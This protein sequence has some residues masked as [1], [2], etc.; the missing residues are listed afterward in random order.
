MATELRNTARGLDDNVTLREEASFQFYDELF[1]KT[2]A[3]YTVKIV[4]KTRLYDSG[5]EYY[6]IGYSYKF[7]PGDLSDPDDILHYRRVL[8]PFYQDNP[9]SRSGEIVRKNKMTGVMIE[10]L[11]TP[12]KELVEHIG[13]TTPQ[14]YK[15]DIMKSLAKFWD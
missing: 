5:I 6:D 10:F 13:M 15:Q 14:R 3:F 11:L 7:S 4:V 1:D 2:T 12:D 9:D 8:H